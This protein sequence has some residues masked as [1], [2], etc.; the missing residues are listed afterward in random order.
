MKIIKRNG[1]EVVFDIMKIIS[2][3][4]RAN[5]VVSEDERLSPMQIRRIA[6]SVEN[7]CLSM[8]RA[9]NVEEIQDLVEHQIMA[10]GAYEVAKNYITYRYTRSLVRKSNTT[11]EK[12]LSLIESNNE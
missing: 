9:L 1:S 8:N 7:S 3:V 2:A 5:N 4:T 12:I 6:E 10:H 11:D